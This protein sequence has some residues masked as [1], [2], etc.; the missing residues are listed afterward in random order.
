MSGVAGSRQG[1]REEF[2]AATAGFLDTVAAV[3]SGDWGRPG[4]GVWDVRALVGHASR[5]FSLIAP[6]LLE[7]ERHAGPVTLDGPVEYYLSIFEPA[8]IDPEARRSLNAGIA[9]R[10]REAG[11]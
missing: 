9:A 2:A 8:S 11:D 3:G 10:G 5:S 7:G 1:W 6:S 4:L